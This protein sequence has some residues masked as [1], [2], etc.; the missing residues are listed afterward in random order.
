MERIES[1]EEESFINKKEHETRYALAKKLSRGI[2]LDIACGIGY[3][4]KILLENNEISRYCGVDISS[5]AIQKANSLYSNNKASFSIGSIKEIQFESNSFDTVISFETL[6]HINIPDHGVKE[7]SRVLKND[8]VFIGSVP[9]QEFD[10]LVEKIYGENKYHISRFDLQ[11]LHNLM[12]K[13]FKYVR[14]FTYSIDMTI[15]IKEIYPSN[16][17]LKISLDKDYDTRQSLYGS[18][19]FICTNQRDVEIE[20]VHLTIVQSYFDLVQPYQSQYTQYAKLKELYNQK[21]IFYNELEQKYQKLYEDYLTI[22]NLY[23]QNQKVTN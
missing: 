10:K 6:E 22:N 15:G 19:F 18:Y 13:Y 5:Q 21:E 17:N 2:V 3:G 12:N 16:N 7:I 4:S 8:G 11:T 9:T 14:I 20:S 23:I 1:F